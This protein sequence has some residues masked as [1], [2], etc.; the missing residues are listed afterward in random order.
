MKIILYALTLILIVLAAPG[1]TNEIKSGSMTG[2][3]PEPTIFNVKSFGAVGDGITLDTKPRQDAIDACS[4]SDGG[5][6]RILPGEYHIGTLRMKSNVA[7]SLDMENCEQQ[8][9]CLKISLVILNNSSLASCPHGA[10][11]SGMPAMLNSEM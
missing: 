2:M 7:L 9:S 8:W 5:I 4:A 1:L 3:S 10:P 6:V 11:I